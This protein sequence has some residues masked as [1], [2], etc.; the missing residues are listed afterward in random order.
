MKLKIGKLE[1]IKFSVLFSSQIQALIFYTIKK[2]NFTTNLIE[3]PWWNKNK[4][5][6][7]SALA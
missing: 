1:S 4:N 3:E 5:Y 6:I 2:V 7:A